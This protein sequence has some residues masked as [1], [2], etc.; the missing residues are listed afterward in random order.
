MTIAFPLSEETL[1][2]YTAYLGQQPLKYRTIKAYLSALRFS[3]IHQGLGDPFD[4]KSMPLLE[5]V[6]AGIKR[7]QAKALPPPKPRLP[8]TPTILAYLQGQWVTANPSHNGLMLWAAACTGFFGFLRAG[9]FTV[10]SAGAYDKDVHLNLADLATD[11]HYRPTLFR[12]RLKQSKTDPLR[13]G[14]DVFLGA[15]N[16]AICPVQ[17]LYKYLEQRGP[18]SGPLFKFASE[19]PLTRVALV[20]HLR[21]ALQQSGFDATAFS[22][23]SFRIGAAT[24]AAK[25]G[26]EDSMIQTLGRWKS[27]AFLA[28]IKIPSEQLTPISAKLVQERP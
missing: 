20:D 24:T 25:R 7:A 21:Q 23:H 9:E 1:C 3:Q 5:Y 26:I 6:L 27:A 14:A 18:S 4:Q 17:A 8:I 15:T 22:G 16:A 2:R 11:C 13:Q 19:A 12:V 28:Y 10:P